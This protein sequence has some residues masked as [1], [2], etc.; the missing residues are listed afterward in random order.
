MDLTVIA[1]FAIGYYL[2]AL[3]HRIKANKSA[4]PILS[5]SKNIHI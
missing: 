5:N 4:L 1:M 2:I 3:K